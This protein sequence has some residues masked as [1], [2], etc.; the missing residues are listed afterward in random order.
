RAFSTTYGF[1]F[2]IQSEMTPEF[3]DARI[4]AF[5]KRYAETLENM[6]EAEFEGHKRSLVIRRLEKLRNLDQESTRH[7]TQ[8][9]SEY[10]DFELARRDAAQV[11]KLTKPEVVEFFNKHFNPASSERARLSIHLHAQGKAEGAE[12]R[13]EEAQKKAD[14]EATAEAGTD[15]TSAVSAAVDITD[16]RGFKANLTVSA[17]P[18]K[19]VGKFQD[20]DAK[21]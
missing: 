1:R 20:T 15:G 11:K 8:I 19:D 3:L 10:Y 18:V 6:S 9:T 2:L 14:E 4:E 5:L 21:P 7:W 17:Q 16:V 13:Q 12:K